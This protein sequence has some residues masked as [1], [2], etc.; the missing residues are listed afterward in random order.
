MELFQEMDALTI[1]ST[2]RQ[3]KL[4]MSKFA[5]VPQMAVIEIAHA[6][7]GA[8]SL[9]QTSFG[10]ILGSTEA[11]IMRHHRLWVQTQIAQLE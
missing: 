10:S 8:T 11:R 5:I 9:V 7:K 2:M 6:Q 4:L 3:E 1:F